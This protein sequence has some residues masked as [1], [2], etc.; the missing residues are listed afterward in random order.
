MDQFSQQSQEDKSK[1]PPP[2]P[3]YD[4][5]VGIR[6]MS[7]DSESIRQS[8]GESPQSEILSANEIFHA[9]ESQQPF[10]PPAASVPVPPQESF[11]QAPR[12]ENL[13]MGPPVK[14]SPVKTVLFIL[15]IIIVAGAV[16]Y[17][18]YYLVVSLNTVPELP[19]VPIVQQ[20]VE[21]SE[22]PSPEISP[23][24]VPA[25]HVSIIPSPASSQQVGISG[26]EL[27]DFKEGIATT[28]R[29]KLLVGTVKDISFVTQQGSVVTSAQF[30]QAF[31][32][33]AAPSLSVVFE[34]DFSAWLYGDKT[35]GNKFGVILEAKPDVSGEQIRAAL[36][37]LETNETELGN[38]FVSSV[39]IPEQTGGFKEGPIDDIVVRYL[40]F[41]AKNQQ[42]FEYVPVKI[43]G[44][45]YAV[46]ATSYYQMSHILK[47]LGATP[48]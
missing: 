32:P 34:D 16:G 15:G 12:Q 47:L 14:K 43:S 31:F 35:G 2:P 39:G 13:T 4:Q 10:T 9:P 40:A 8:G 45:T 20:T 36:S 27:V 28:T 7:S 18:A 46:I 48:L 42:V 37:L 44:K 30:L 21:P 25:M 11:E 33:S 22:L 26:V 24:V 17:G 1:V 19:V 41:S 38:M 6:T 29:E 3:S 5:Q 23:I